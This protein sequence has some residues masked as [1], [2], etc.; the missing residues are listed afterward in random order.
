MK[1]EIIA[2]WERVA[3]EAL[4]RAD[5]ATKGPWG[6][7]DGGYVFTEDGGQ[8]T[9]WDLFEEI[10]GAEDNAANC[11]FVAS[12]RQDVPELAEAV[13]Q[14]AYALRIEKDRYKQCD[15]LEAQ[16]YALKDAMY[17]ALGIKFDGQER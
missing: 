10:G 11:A 2:A 8:G 7:T 5:A 16:Y 9:P 15:K 6:A 1:D 4:V 12:A 3:S 13:K 14:L 17:K